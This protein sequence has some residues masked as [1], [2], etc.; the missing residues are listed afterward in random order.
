M[1][2]TELGSHSFWE[3][4]KETVNDDPEMKVRGHDKFDENFYVEIGEERFLI[5]MDGGRV[6]EVVPNPGLNHQWAFGVEGERQAWQEFVEETPPAFNHEII[7]SNYRS[8]VRNEA[9]HLELTGDN[10]KIFQNLRAFQ[11]TLDLLRK[12]KNNGGNL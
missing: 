4:Y 11:R 1:S 2:E 6:D 7:A 9:G 12:A 3:H 10:K 8:A 5:V